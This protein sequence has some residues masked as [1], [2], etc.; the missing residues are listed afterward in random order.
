MKIQFDMFGPYIK[1]HVECNLTITKSL[2]ETF[3]FTLI[4]E[5]VAYSI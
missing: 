3:L 4:L 1:D 5:L 2:I